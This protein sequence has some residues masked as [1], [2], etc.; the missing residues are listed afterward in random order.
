MQEK[1]VRSSIAATWDNRWVRFRMALKEAGVEPRAHEFCRGWVLRFIGFIKPAKFDQCSREDLERFFQ[2]MQAESKEVWQIRQA[3]ESLRLFYQEVEPLEWAKDWPEDLVA[4]AQ[5]RRQSRLS[6]PESRD[7][8]KVER[9]PTESGA[10]RFAGRRD[11][12][13]LP[14]KYR[15]FVE[16]VE[17]TLRT[18]R[19]SYRT[20]QSYLEWVRRFLIF[21]APRSRR[22]LDW[23]D[24]KAYLDY[25]T[26][27]RRVSSGTQNQALSAL[28]FLYGTVLKRSAGGKKE[29]QRAPQ[30]RRVPTVLTRQEIHLLLTSRTLQGI[31]G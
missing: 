24:A 31:D 27:V 15:A 11:T 9:P 21:S 28:Q 17:E 10:A 2:K 23:E 1:S 19:Y 29:I 3:E 18:E 12:G 4:E 7:P 8:A 25:L 13:E 14:D 6:L 20:E 22:E 16:I 30:S 26:L 5:A